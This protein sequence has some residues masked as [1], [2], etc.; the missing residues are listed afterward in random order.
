LSRPWPPVVQGKMNKMK[1]R[2][3]KSIMATFDLRI[4]NRRRDMVTYTTSGLSEDLLLVLRY[5][6]CQLYIFI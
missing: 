2:T 5:R 4:V 1:L 3:R 6:V